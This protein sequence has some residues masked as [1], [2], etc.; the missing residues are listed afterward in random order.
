MP[1]PSL[2]SNSIKMTSNGQ[3]E[4]DGDVTTTTSLANKPRERQRLVV[5]FNDVDQIA[6][7]DDARKIS[8]GS[9]H[10]P[11]DSTEWYPALT[12]ESMGVTRQITRKAKLMN[13]LLDDDL[14]DYVE[15]S[16]IKNE[17]F[18]PNRRANTIVKKS[19]D[20]RFQKQVA[21]NPCDEK[22]FNLI[23]MIAILHAS[24]ILA[25]LIMIQI[26]WDGTKLEWITSPYVDAC[27]AVVS[28]STIIA[29]TFTMIVRN[30]QR[31]E[32]KKV[33]RQHLNKQKAFKLSLCVEYVGIILHMPPFT[34]RILPEGFGWMDQ[35]NIIVFFRAYIIFELL[36]VR[37]PLWRLRKINFNKRGELS[38]ITGIY[39]I[40]YSMTNNPL[41]FFFCTS[42]VLLLFLTA[43]M[44]SFERWEQ[45]DMELRTALYHMIIV[46]TSV[47]LG[48]VTCLTWLGRMLTMICATNGIVFL[49]ILM[50]QLFEAIEMQYDEMEIKENH[51]KIMALIE[52]R[53]FA[54]I[55][56]QRWW[57]R[58]K[59]KRLKKGACVEKHSFESIWDYLFTMSLKD[60]KDAIQEHMTI[61]KKQSVAGVTRTTQALIERLK[62]DVKKDMHI[63]I[64]KISQLQIIAQ[65][66]AEMLEAMQRKQ[67]I[68]QKKSTLHE[69]K[70]ELTHTRKINRKKRGY[71]RRRSSIS[72]IVME[73]LTPQFEGV[74]P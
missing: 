63:L 39:F 70:C 8:S 66:N 46:F 55:I 62:I 42:C 71:M 68:S 7:L 48:D 13:I 24:S 15:R 18:Q 35:C 1:V 11:W 49:S 44:V 21:L 58:H 40:K 29:F 65:G 56:I 57:K 22:Q 9:E 74:K 60:A 3:T 54:A 20:V 64:K 33:D 31:Q 41:K 69:A 25:T 51:L 38:S 43:A 14:R 53:N 12:D 23:N 37:S 5:E 19:R 36:R 67:K 27:K 45:P 4:G 72:D 32:Y 2:P 47:G 10:V 26:G 61:A 16:T 52:Y 30:E 73:H 59:R 28:I 17:E 34:S 6:E 50:N